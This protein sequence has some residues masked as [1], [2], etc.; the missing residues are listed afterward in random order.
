MFLFKRFILFINILKMAANSQSSED[1][2]RIIIDEKNNDVI[3]GKG[4][5]ILNLMSLIL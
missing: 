5:Y 2:E 4:K 1:S 3:K